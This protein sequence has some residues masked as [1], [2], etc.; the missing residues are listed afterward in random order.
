MHSA[1]LYRA[2]LNL[3]SQG[4]TFTLLSVGSKLLMRHDT[5]M[6][7]MHVGRLQCGTA[8]VQ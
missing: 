1:D 3:G 5:C 4:T 8:E 6:L 2:Q 7:Y